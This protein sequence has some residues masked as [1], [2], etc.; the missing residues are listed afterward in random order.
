MMKENRQ[1][2][3]TLT[4][5]AFQSLPMEY[6]FGCSNFYPATLTSLQPIWLLGCHR[7]SRPKSSMVS[8]TTG[9][10]HVVPLSN[11]FVCGCWHDLH[12][13][14]MEHLFLFGFLPT[15]TTLIS[16]TVVKSISTH[17]SLAANTV[18][19]AV[20]PLTRQHVTC[21]IVITTPLDEST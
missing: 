21:V 14:V 5:V 17:Q 12:Y 20:A 9:S 8:S 18:P 16:V 3:V 7:R 6:G 13:H 19:T 11:I 1:S 10:K 4:L 2:S 15:T